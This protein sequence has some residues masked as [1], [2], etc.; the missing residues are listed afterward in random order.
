[1][2][3]IQQI[4]IWCTQVLYGFAEVPSTGAKT[5]SRPNWRI[6]WEREHTSFLKLH[7]NS[8]LVHRDSLKPSAQTV[9]TIS[10]WLFTNTQWVP[11]LPT[12]FIWFCRHLSICTSILFC[13]HLN[14]GQYFWLVKRLFITPTCCQ[15]LTVSEW[16]CH[17][18]NS[19]A[20]TESV[21]K[22]TKLLPWFTVFSLLYTVQSEACYLSVQC[23]MCIVQCIMWSV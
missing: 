21:K 5:T 3:P 22:H 4:F 13:S 20:N 12:K 6:I 17:L 11:F 15:L 7:S 1:M 8:N 14:L 10:R 9:Y 19:H 2:D 18:C 23:S 16:L